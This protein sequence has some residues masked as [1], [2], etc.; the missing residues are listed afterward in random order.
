[1]VVVLLEFMQRLL[2]LIAIAAGVSSSKAFATNAKSLAVTVTAVFFDKFSRVAIPLLVGALVLVGSGVGT[3]AVF[4]RVEAVSRYWDASNTPLLL[5]VCNVVVGII[6]VK[7]PYG[8]K[9]FD[10]AKFG[11]G[12]EMSLKMELLYLMGGNG[13]AMKQFSRLFQ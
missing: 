5:F 11:M 9:D 8:P 4:P 12:K 10:D 1:M 6:P 13:G 2:F 3:S 7:Y